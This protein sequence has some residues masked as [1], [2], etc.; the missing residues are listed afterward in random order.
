MNRCAGFTLNIY[1]KESDL[2]SLRWLPFEEELFFRLA[3]LHLTYFMIL[4]SRI[5]LVFSLKVLKENSVVI[6]TVNLRLRLEHTTK[7]LQTL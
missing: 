1:A 2:I 4:V 5:T 6:T 3:N 7:T